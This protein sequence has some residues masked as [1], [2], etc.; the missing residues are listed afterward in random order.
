MSMEGVIAAAG[1][2]RNE[3]AEVRSEVNEAVLRAYRQHYVVVA[4]LALLLV[5]DPHNAE[6][7]AHEAFARLHLKW[8][9]LEDK[10]SVLPYLRATVV[11]LARS[12]NRRRRI[13]ARHPQP[14]ER[15][16]AATEDAAIAN[17]E[18]NRVIQALAR[19]PERQRAAIVLR[20]YLRMTDDDIAI[21]MG[22]SV[23][24]VRTHLQRASAALSTSLGALDEP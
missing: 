13:V 16:S 17:V 6:V 10:E 2:V 7:V 24:T 3:R 8:D 15:P 22:C 23:G 1:F 5:G 4:R 20:H 12:N 21:T 19:L 18:G 14:V 9:R 11:N